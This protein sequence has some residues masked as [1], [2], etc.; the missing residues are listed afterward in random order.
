M[1]DK[2]TF[3]HWMDDLLLLAIFL[4]LTCIIHKLRLCVTNNQSS[5]ISNQH[6][7]IFTS[8]DTTK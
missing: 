2:R 8:K 6:L 5:I 1:C 7:N 4:I 3:Y